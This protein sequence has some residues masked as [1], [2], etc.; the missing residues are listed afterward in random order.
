MAYLGELRVN[1]RAL[2]AATIGLASALSINGFIH[3]V[4][5]PHLIRDFGWTREQFALIGSIQIL[6]FIM[7]PIAG[8]MADLFGV[9][10]TAMTGV[11]I[12]PLTF[13]AMSMMTG[14]FS[15]Y[16]AIQVVQLI[17]CISTTTTVYCRLVAERFDAAR[18]LAL[19]MMACGPQLVAA[20]GSPLLELYIADHGWR[21]GCIAFAI[22]SGCAGAVAMLLM[23]ST[24]VRAKEAVAAP[25]RRARTDYQTIF[26][27]RAFWVI[28]IGSLLS[29]VPF[30]LSQS[31]LNVMLSDRD[32]PPAIAQ[33]GVTLFAAGMIAGRVLMG[34]SLDRF[35]THIV[36]ALGVA[37]TAFGLLILAAPFSGPI[38]VMVGVTLFG[39]AYGAEADILGFAVVRYFGMGV[40]SSVLGLLNGVVAVAMFSGSMMLSFTLNMT[41]SYQLFML[42]AALLSVLGALNF[43]RM[44]SLPVVGLHGAQPVSEQRDRGIA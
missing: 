2:V 5:G 40:Y 29:F 36:A 22:F 20:L 13:V 25:A 12:Y 24:R 32:L 43:L 21:A 28:L 3:S 14:A 16:Y 30:A 37:L 9:R 27:S 23:P 35:P 11:I 26:A 39:I 42:I 4:F 44:R 41:G 10:A 18:G 34:A 8:R 17:F 6:V 15:T 1:W 19:G 38:L 33:S 31:Q 7:N